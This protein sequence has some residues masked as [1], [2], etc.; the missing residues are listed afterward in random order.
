MK[1]LWF[2]IINGD[3]NPVMRVNVCAPYDDKPAILQKM[4]EM[5][6]AGKL[7]GILTVKFPDDAVIIEMIC[8]LLRCYY[9]GGQVSGI[10]W[11]SINGHSIHVALAGYS[12]ANDSARK[13]KP[14]LPD[15]DDGPNPHDPDL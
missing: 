9:K 15:Q 11:D 5:L 6:M 10:H 12:S 1:M 4:L 2:S 8:N 3:D 14:Q 7:I 13:E